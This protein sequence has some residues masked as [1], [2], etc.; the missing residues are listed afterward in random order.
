MTPRWKPG[1]TVA[2]VVE[3]QG[4]FL[5]VEEETPSGLRLN[6]P[7]GHLDAGES[8][9]E[10]CIRET[11]EESAYQFTPQALVG[12]YLW[13]ASDGSGDPSGYLRFAFCGVLGAHDPTQAL[14]HGIVR[15]LWLSLDEVRASAARHRNPLVLQ[16]IED[17]LRG[18][19]YPLELLY[20]HPA[21]S[22]P[23]AGTAAPSQ[24]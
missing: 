5:L 3:N 23:G 10:A 13:R 24:R 1:V 22:P 20:T 12:S 15:T 9:I 2:A 21:I 16:C 17:Y 11:R 19:R 8:L 18:C 6:N 7:A 14:D 4:K